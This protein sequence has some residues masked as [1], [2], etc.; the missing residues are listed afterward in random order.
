MAVVSFHYQRGMLD[1]VIVGRL[2]VDVVI[3]WLSYSPVIYFII[4]FKTGFLFVVLAVPTHFVK[5][6]D[7]K[8]A[9]IH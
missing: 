5:K 7:I 2:W 3:I 4:I 9:E 6:I 8:L 1:A